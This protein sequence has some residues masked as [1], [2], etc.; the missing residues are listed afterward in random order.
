MCGFAGIINIKRLANKEFLE[1]RLRKAYAYLRSRG[2][3][4]K[5]MW[6]DKNSYF[7]HTRLKILDLKGTASQPMEYGDHVISYNGEIYN[8]QDLKNRLIRKGYKFQSS[9]DTEVLLASWQYWGPDVLNRLDG[10]FAFSIWDKKKKIIYFDR[11]R[12]GKKPLVFSSS[13]NSISFASDIRSLKEIAYEGK[14]NKLAIESLF[15]FRFIYEPLTI[16]DNFKKL[17]AGCYLKFCSNGIEVKK[18]FRLNN[19]ISNLNE[20]ESQRKIIEL[21]TK[22]VEKRLIS[23]VPIGVF[24]SGGIDSGIIS[25]CL[26]NLNKKIPHFTVGFKNEGD[27]YNEVSSAS[28]LAKYFGFEHNALYLDVKKIKPLIDEITATCDEPF[29]D[30]SAIPTY[31]VAKETSQYMKV[32]LSGDGGDEVFGGYRKYMSYR[33]NKLTNL[34][35]NFLRKNLG[36]SLPNF[37]HNLFSEKI[38]KLK[39]LLLNSS[40]DLN[41]MQVSFL[42]QLSDLECNELLGVKKTNLEKYVFN[43]IAKFDDSLN[44]ILARDI[45]FSLPGDML[46]KVDRFSMRHSLEVRSP[47]LDKDLVDYAFSISGKEKI[48]FFKGKKVLRKAFTHMLPEKYLNF[49]KKGFEVPLDKWLLNELK[50]LVEKS[51]SNKVIESLGIKNKKIIENW[52][53]DFFGGKSDNSWKLWTLISYARWAELNKFI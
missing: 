16:Y 52:K 43:D 31:M 39:R 9:G 36:A 35:P 24:L 47:F 7:L 44:Q 12:F 5:G 14:L 42:D 19:K 13:E 15:R 23:D 37:K 48:G 17:P 3:D 8:F 29:A 21:T 25:S 46:V 32:A 34:L 28:N 51:S 38:R 1:R 49:P 22:A 20:K 40:L 2:P 27:Y 45:K 53:N 4:E 11:D 50:Y 26:A 33:W 6:H 10:M 30:S 41:K 18:W